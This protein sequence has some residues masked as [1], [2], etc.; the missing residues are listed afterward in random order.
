MPQPACH[1]MT[2]YCR[3]DGFGDH[4]TDARPFGVGIIAADMHDEIGLSSPHPMLDRRTKF[5]GPGHPVPRWEQGPDYL[6]ESGSQ[7][8]TALAA[9]AGDDG[10]AGAGAHP[11]PEPMHTCTAPVVGLEGPLALSHGYFSSLH[12][13]FAS[14]AHNTLCAA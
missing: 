3:T 4:Q 8:A 12:L 5:G 14:A 7:R 10:A 9:P 11:Q 6:T 1:L 2:L 13:A